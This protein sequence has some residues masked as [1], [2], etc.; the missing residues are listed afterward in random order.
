MTNFPLCFP[1]KV[2]RCFAYENHRS[3][4]PAVCLKMKKHPTEV[5]CFLFSG[6]AFTTRP[7]LNVTVNHVTYE[8]LNTWNSDNSLENGCSSPTSMRCHFGNGGRCF[9]FFSLY[10]ILN[11]I[12]TF[13]GI[14]SQEVTYFSVVR[15]NTASALPLQRN[16]S[17]PTSVYSIHTGT[18]T[19]SELYTR[20]CLP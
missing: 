6:Q 15:A 8:S 20:H 13:N 10:M 9:P 5:R 11:K 4:L 3:L 2:R 16:T 1:R 17:T 12:V 14:S 7:R 19:E 18:V